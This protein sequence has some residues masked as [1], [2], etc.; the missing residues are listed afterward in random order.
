MS[1]KSNQPLSSPSSQ[2]VGNQDSNEPRMS[3]LNLPPAPRLS[4]LNLPPPPSLNA[5][6]LPPPPPINALNLPPPPPLNTLNLPIPPPITALNLPPS[7][8]FGVPPPIQ[9]YRESQQY[10]DSF[11]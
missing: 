8:N 4:T 10:S 3:N 6:N 7:N 2:N 1:L 9:P 11:I 5:L